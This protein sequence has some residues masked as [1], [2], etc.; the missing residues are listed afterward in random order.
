MDRRRKYSS[1]PITASAAPAWTGNKK[2]AMK[3]DVALF[4]IVQV[5][6]QW[7]HCPADTSS[8]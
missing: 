8:L 7:E 1:Q 4:K 2:E 3:K 5:K 6:V